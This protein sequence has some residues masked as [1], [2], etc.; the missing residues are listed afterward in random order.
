MPTAERIR[1]AWLIGLHNIAEGITD[2]TIRRGLDVRDLSL[3]AYGAAGPM[4]LPGLLDVLR[5]RA[6][7]SRRTRVGSARS[8]C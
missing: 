6:S 1:Q 4:M 7:S 3:M 8:A 2:I 5:W